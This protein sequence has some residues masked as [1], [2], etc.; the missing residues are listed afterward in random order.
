[1]DIIYD[2]INEILEKLK[3]KEYINT[4]EMYNR[5]KPL[6][7]ITDKE[8]KEY[9]PE[10]KNN[11]KYIEEW[12]DLIVKPNKS[13]Q[14]YQK[15]KGCIRQFAFW[16]EEENDGVS[17]SRLKKR[18][19]MKYQNYLL[20]TGMSKATLELK[21]NTVS[22]FCN[23]LEVYISEEDPKYETFRNFVKGTEVPQGKEKIY[24]KQPVS[25]EEYLKVKTVLLKA[26]MFRLHAIWVCLF[27]TG[28]RIA[29]ILQ[30]K[31]SD[32]KSIPK[33]KTYIE[34]GIVRGKGAGITGKLF[35]IRLNRE[36]I[37]ALLLY[38][39]Y[40]PKVDNEY[41]FYGKNSDRLQILTVEREF[42]TIISTI[43]NRRCNPHLL[44]GS[45]ATYLLN[46][47]VSLTTV[48]EL[49]KHSD[50]STTSKFYDLRDKDK[51]IDDELEELGL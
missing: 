17:F 21:R 37:Q 49:L 7:P 1:M 38:K 51:L 36:C 5:S 10:T 29:E 19:F 34:S 8:W 26:K 14:T 30:L 39:K 44:R 40:R 3:N 45:F 6:K 18:A 15:Y 50:V 20:S 2:D 13:P 31:M 47:G 46:K 43:L 41:I 24:D 35:T 32:I 23:F 4:Q 48:K 22:S 25:Y 9:I 16:N 11:K 12:L 33:D 42:Q 27:F 28:K